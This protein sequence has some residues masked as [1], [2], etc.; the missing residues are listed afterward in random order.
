MPKK[1]V[2]KTTKKVAPK[3]VA[4][5]KV[6]KKA[7][8]KKAAPAKQS[9]L[10]KKYLHTETEEFYA[11]HPNVKPLLIL[12]LLIA[13]AVFIYLVKIRMAVLAM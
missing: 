5:K 10:Q 12:F 9:L 7:P 2:K 11:A 1:A 8:A 4:K 3:K 13:T 6:T